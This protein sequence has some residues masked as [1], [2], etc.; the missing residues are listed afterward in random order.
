MMFAKCIRAPYGANGLEG[1]EVG[2][3]YRCVLVDTG[4]SVA[5]FGRYYRVYPEGAD[6]ASPDY[7]ETAPVGVFKRYFTVERG[8]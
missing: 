2:N 4:P 6:G 7:Y 3:V 8:D 5:L 1:Y